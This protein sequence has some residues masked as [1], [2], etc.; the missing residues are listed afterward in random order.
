MSWIMLKFHFVQTMGILSDYNSWFSDFLP[1][2]ISVMYASIM[3]LRNSTLPLLTYYQNSVILWYWMSCW[4]Y[5]KVVHFVI[6]IAYFSMIPFEVFHQQYQHHET[7]H[8]FNCHNRGFTDQILKNWMFEN[9]CAISFPRNLFW[10]KHETKSM[11][12]N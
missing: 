8:L 2:Y 9:I 12:C 11:T 6:F 4:I 1:K 7:A 10:L 3:F 5:L